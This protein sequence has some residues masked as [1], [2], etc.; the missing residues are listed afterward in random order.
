MTDDPVALRSGRRFRL[1]AAY[2]RFRLGRNFHAIRLARDGVPVPMAWG[3][4]IVVYSNHPS[5]WDPALLILLSDSLFRGRPGFGP[6]DEKSFRR[7]GIFRRLGV[8]GIAT[9]EPRGARRFLAISRDALAAPGGMMWI[10]AEGRFTDPRARPLRLRPGIAHLARLRP[11]AAFLPLAIEYGFWEESRPEVFVRFGP[12]V[13]LEP[14]LSVTQ[15]ASR[16]GEALEANMTALAA[17]VLSHEPARFT[18]IVRGA[19]GTDVFYDGGR[20]LRA[21]LRGKRFRAAHRAEA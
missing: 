6:M 20:R 12:P 2:L 11:E 9:E 5:W 4:P 16:L 19:T 7:Y 15:A 21:A 10:T 8:F 18:T 1:F 13:S 14:E 17:S 3:R